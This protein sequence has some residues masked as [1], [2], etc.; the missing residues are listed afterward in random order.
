M[1]NGISRETYAD[2]DL[3]S[4][5]MVIYD[6]VKEIHKVIH[7]Q[8][9]A[10]QA[11]ADSCDARIKTLETRKNRDTAFSGMMGFVGGFLAVATTW[12]RGTLK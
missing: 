9:V 3:K 8:P 10:C 1:P 12:L 6:M 11:R 4:Q 7:E 5:N 2:L